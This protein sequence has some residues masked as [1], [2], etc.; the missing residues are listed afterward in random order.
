MKTQ[1][2]FNWSIGNA[3]L[4]KTARKLALALGVA[5]K[6]ISFNLPARKACPGK[7][8]CSGPCYAVQGRYGLPEAQRVRAENF[9]LCK[10]CLAKSEGS[11]VKALDTDI[12]AIKETTKSKLVFRLHDSGDFFSPAYIRAWIRLSYMHPDSLFYAYTKSTDFVPLFALNNEIPNLVVCCSLGGKHDRHTLA[13]ADHNPGI[14][15]SR[16]F[17]V[18][19]TGAKGQ[20]LQ[21][22]KDKA[23]DTMTSA[24]YVDGNS[25]EG[26]LTLILARERGINRIG[27]VYHGSKKMTQPQAKALAQG[28]N[29]E[30]L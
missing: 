18:V 5:I 29:H 8:A 3:K 24:G 19:P 27:L 30:I 17:P 12:C 1:H 21:E 7:G 15:L 22:D 4:I 25:E 28:G 2:K 26:D 10:A 20:V 23:H 16:I 6:L 9:T 13:L 14:I 11:L